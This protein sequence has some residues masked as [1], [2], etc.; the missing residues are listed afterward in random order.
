MAN[1]YLAFLDQKADQ[2][3]IPREYARAVMHQESRGNP[4]AVSPVGAQGLMQ[5]MPGTAR[6]LGIDPRDPYQNME[7]GV[8]YLAE[9]AKKYGLTG[10]L[11]DKNGGTGRWEKA[12]AD[13]ALRPQ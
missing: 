4:N 11:A 7:G 5:I 6:D 3:G 9:N 8:R 10:A 2:Y 13:L 1:A 12:G